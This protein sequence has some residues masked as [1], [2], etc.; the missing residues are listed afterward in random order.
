MVV[1]T[2]IQSQQA[3]DLAL[4]VADEMDVNIG[5]EVGYSIPLEKCCATET[6]LRC[7]KAVLFTFT[8]QMCPLL[9]CL[10]LS[11]LHIMHSHDTLLNHPAFSYSQERGEQK[12]RGALFKASSTAARLPVDPYVTLTMWVPHKLA[13]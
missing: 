8:H 7:A 3:V 12:T 2:Q 10:T 1:C 9:L 4:R 5:H 11:P 13:E 6:V